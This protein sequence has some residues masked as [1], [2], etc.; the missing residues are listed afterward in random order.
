MAEGSLHEAMWSQRFRAAGDTY[1]FGTEPNRYLREHAGLLPA[2]GSLLCVADGEGRNSVWLAGQGFSVTATEISPVGIDK[3]RR[4][5]ARAGVSVDYQLCD[6]LDW[7]APVAAY[8]AV[9]AIFIQFATAAEQPGLFAQLKTALKP[10]GVLLLLG[11]TP[12]QLD[13]RTGGPPCAEQLYDE[14]L[15][16]RH[17]A[18]CEILRLDV[19][20][21]VLDEG[22]GHSGRS[23]LIGLVARRL[24]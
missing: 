12:K 19:F 15:L 9:V 22:T 4:L 20:E 21:D 18:D 7:Q 24:P 11:Y 13:Y 14:T 23:A 10:G 5:A 6:I 2:G 16:R 3:A 1:L 8:D 17:F